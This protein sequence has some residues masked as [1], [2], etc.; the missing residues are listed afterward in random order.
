[1]LDPTKKIYALI[2]CNNFFV[3]CERVF[4]PH[5]NNKPVAVLSNNDGCIVARSNEVKQLGIPMGAP[6][7]KYKN[8]VLQHNI[9]LFSSN[10]SLYKDFSSR[11]MQ[12]ILF[13]YPDLEIYSIDEA[14]IQFIS[15]DIK[16]IEIAMLKLQSCILKW[17]GIPV[18]IGV[19]AT[20][21]LAKFAA[22]HSKSHPLSKPYIVTDPQGQQNIFESTSIKKIW[23]IGRR[24]AFRLNQ[25]GIFNAY[26]FIQTCPN[27]IRKICSISTIQTQL[28]LKGIPCLNV[29]NRFEHKSLVYSRS[30]STPITSYQDLQE[31]ISYYTAQAAS[32]LRLYRRQTN[33][34]CLFL[35]TNRFKDS[36][37]PY[38]TQTLLTMDCPTNNTSLLIKAA[39]KG[40]DKIFKKDREY[41]KA[42]IYFPHLIDAN[43]AKQLS[44][45]YSSTPQPLDHAITLM[46]KINSR[47]GKNTLSFAAE[48][49]QKPWASSREKQSN[50]Y[51]TEWSELC[52]IS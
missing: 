7:F 11:V 43:S 33:I 45:F 47:F 16:N 48:G 27:K 29:D 6:L 12:T 42:G 15:T 8:L 35:Q 21:T 13:F 30:F 9:H 18:S 5:L 34:I 22:I 3:S 49:F 37:S 46:D 51:T 38:H 2:D 31:T 20:K 40:L 39:L 50:R 25:H 10:F 26:E 4:Q 36:T 24:C 32:K 41:K 14:F 19:G 1:M 23:G 44:L 52:Y 17:T 28:E